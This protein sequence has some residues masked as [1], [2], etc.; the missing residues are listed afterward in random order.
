MDKD[1]KLMVVLSHGQI[2][3]ICAL[4]ND[5]V[6]EIQAKDEPS[7]VEKQLT[8][9]AEDAK[10]RIAIAIATQEVLS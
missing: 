6:K 3:L 8:H 9:I 7:P 10:E 2:F 4:L 5:K 1:Q